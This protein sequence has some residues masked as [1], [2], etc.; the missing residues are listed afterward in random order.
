MEVGSEISSNPL[1]VAICLGLHLG[2]VGLMVHLDLLD[3]TL[4]LL[5]IDLH[6][7]LGFGLDLRDISLLLGL[8]LLGLIILL[9]RSI[10]RHIDGPIHDPFEII[11]S[12][13]ARHA[14]LE[15]F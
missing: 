7:G 8:L 13:E 3:L 15:H 5:L 10:Q 12:F 14:P 6:I 1:K 9:W 2:H 11:R 4:H